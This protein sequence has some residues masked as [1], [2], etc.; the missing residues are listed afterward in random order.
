MIH[1]CNKIDSLSKHVEVSLLLQIAN[2]SFLACHGEMYLDKISF[3]CRSPSVIVRLMPVLSVTILFSMCFLSHILPPFIFEPKLVPIGDTCNLVQRISLSAE[4][5]TGCKRRICG[6]VLS[7]A[8]YGKWRPRADIT[9]RDVMYRKKMDSEI[10]LRM[11]VP[12]PASLYRNDSRLMHMFVL[13]HLKFSPFIASCFA[14]A[15]ALVHVVFCSKDRQIVAS[16]HHVAL[17]NTF[18]TRRP[19]QEFHLSR[20]IIYN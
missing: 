1:I 20:T 16:R 6:S 2:G 19:V 4:S 17:K 14:V 12:W 9:K 18:S 10:R 15:F 5:E 13:F 7:D 3:Y 11:K 8:V